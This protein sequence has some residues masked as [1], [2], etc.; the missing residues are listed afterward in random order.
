M[1]LNIRRINL[2]RVPKEKRQ[3][4]WARLQK[5]HPAHARLM[6]DPL[7]QAVREKFNAQ[8]IVELPVNTHALRES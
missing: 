6:N 1:S 3:E 2:S 4:A 7:V 5:K 8:V